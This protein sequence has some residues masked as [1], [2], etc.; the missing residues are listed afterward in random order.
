LC[1]FAKIDLPK[2]RKPM[3]I[4]LGKILLIVNVSKV[5]YLSQKRK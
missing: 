1:L 4:Y 5:Y 3:E 2:L